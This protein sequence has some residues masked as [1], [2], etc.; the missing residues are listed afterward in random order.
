[1]NTAVED[2]VDLTVRTVSTEYRHTRVRDQRRKC[3][4]REPSSEQLCFLKVNFFT[5]KNISLVL[6]RS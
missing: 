3:A 6:E 2:G 5:M 4:G 1:M